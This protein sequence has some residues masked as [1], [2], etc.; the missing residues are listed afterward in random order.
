MSFSILSAM[1]V[2]GGMGLIF[3]IGLAIASRVFHVDKDARVVLVEEV[4]PGVNCGAC[5]AP[6]CS[7][8]AEGVVNKKYDVNGCIPGGEDTAVRIADIMG[9][10][11][12]SVT[13]KVAIIRCR[14]GDANTEKRAFY[15]GINECKAAT[16]ISNGDNGCVYGC[17]GLGSCVE[18]CPFDALYMGGNGLPVVYEDKCTGCGKCVEACPRNIIELLP[19]DKKIFIACVSKAFGKAVKKVCKV[20]CIGCGLCSKPKIV[21]NEVITMDGKIPV[22]HYDKSVN[23]V[24][25][26]EIAVDKCPNDCFI[27]RDETVRNKVEIVSEMEMAK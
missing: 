23:L 3:G 21:P 11:V 7:G 10:K 24:K 1:L 27:N 16:L 19:V 17:L 6:G 15:Q 18:V 25:D 2:L 9:S 5:G 26:L 13:P 20:G 12:D 4:L 22:I 14:G 8:F